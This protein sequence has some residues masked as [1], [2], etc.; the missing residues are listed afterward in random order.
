MCLDIQL[1]PVDRICEQ[2]RES[3]EPKGNTDYACI[4]MYLLTYAATVIRRSARVR[5]LKLES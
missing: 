3:V 4:I 1:K 2:H 5:S